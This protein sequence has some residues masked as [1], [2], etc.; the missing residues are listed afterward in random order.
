MKTYC[1]ELKVL[2]LDEDKAAKN[3]GSNSYL[4]DTKDEALGLLEK[5]SVEAFLS[6]T[7]S[8]EGAA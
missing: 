7:P 2:E 4:Y 8:P 6:D 5:L 3:I 1:L